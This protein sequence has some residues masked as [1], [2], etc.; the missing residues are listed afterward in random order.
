MREVSIALF[1]GIGRRV[2]ALAAA[3]GLAALALGVVLQASLLQRDYRATHLQQLRMSAAE[4]AQL[5]RN[6]IDS[7]ALLLR[8][9][10]DAASHGSAAAPLVLAQLRR[11]PMFGFVSV[12]GP[13]G[14]TFQADHQDFRLDPGE[15]EA[16]EAGAT[17]LVGG[18]DAGS[19][20]KLYLLRATGGPEKPVWVLAELRGDWVWSEFGATDARLAVFDSRGDRHFGSRASADRVAREV[21][22]HLTS[23]PMGSSFDLAWR[24][25]DAAWSGSMVRI[26]SAST[27]SGFALA[28]VAMDP[29]RPWSAAFWS[30]L[31]SQAPAILLLL[32]LVAWLTSV[33]AARLIHPL[34]QLRRALLQLPDRRLRVAASPRQFGEV[35]QLVDAY[36]RSAEAIETQSGMRRVLDELDALLLP[37]G[38]YESVIDQVL[39]RVRAVTRATNVGLTLVDPGIAG[40]GRLYAVSAEGG[41]PVNRVVLD[42]SMVA[43]LRD[44]EEGLTIA[45]CEPDRH[46]FL[47]PLHAAGSNFFWVWP[48]M[49]SDELA[50]ILTVGYAEPPQLAARIADTGMLCAQRLGLSLSNS[51]RAERLYRQAHYDPLTQ[52]PN[53]QLFREQLQQELDHLQ[54]EDSRGAL[55]YIDLDHFKRVNDSLG[56]E[57]GDKL[58]AIVAQRLLGCVKQGDTVA[59]LG[60]DEF[61]VILRSVSDKSEVADIAERIVS[62]MRQSMWLGG[63]DHHVQA[64]I[65]VTMFPEDG[66]DLDQLLHHADLAMYRA[67]D[68]GRSGAVFYSSTIEKR[69]VR[70]ADS[71]LYRAIRQRE[72]NLYYQPQYRFSDGMLV[73]IEALLRWHRPREGV[74]SPSEFIAA[75]EESGIIVDIGVWVIDAACAQIAQWRAA[76]VT[77]PRMALNLSAQ[78]L[79][80]PDL[81]GELQRQLDQHHLQPDAIEF[82]MS[83]AVLADP[84]CA[85]SIEALSQLGVRL[86]LDDFG[87]GSTALANLRRYPVGAVKIDCSYVA[88]LT[89]SPSAAA[90]ADTIIVMAHSQRKLVIAEGIETLQQLEYLRERGCDVA[91]G[92]FLARPLS[93][94]DM[95]EMLLGNRDRRGPLRLH[96]AS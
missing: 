12:L 47:E 40:Y 94:S 65:G 54:S 58:L 43:A 52:L 26:R 66:T 17:V 48:V 59:R 33:F 27:T 7:A 15:R 78:Q 46:S 44:A 74:V 20:G 36:N 18:R 71:G 24:E 72:F 76:G 11:V 34:R 53:R 8:M 73:G 1:S 69:N 51:A 16:L 86:T 88:Q 96:N 29:D 19:G 92:F 38:D 75:A 95:T 64:S 30:V 50:A 10:I 85:P 28:V 42:P 49:A 93:A 9:Q 14:E 82:E 2:A 5:A 83:E 56:H 70:I 45:R 6:R 89:E 90:L 25:G 62:A 57:A 37:G 80:D 21:V 39:T 32:V 35:R 84:L 68:L 79:R 41:S 61:T 55:L 23:V 31:R 87:T 77:V 91:Q 81:I 4:T 3:C 60:G 63:R 13:T 22:A 67:K